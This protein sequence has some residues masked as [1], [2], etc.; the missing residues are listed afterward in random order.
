MTVTLFARQ[1]R[2]LAR[3][4]PGE[5][6]DFVAAQH[7]SE[8][9][10][11]RLGEAPMLRERRDR[12]GVVTASGVERADCLVLAIGSDPTTISRV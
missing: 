12:I 1:D 11:L 4:V 6:A 10:K 9:V 3:M 8:G 5:V 2:V 7:R